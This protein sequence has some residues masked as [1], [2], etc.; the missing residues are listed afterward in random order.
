MHH[1]WRSARIGKDDAGRRTGRSAPMKPVAL[2]V[3]SARHA[4]NP[5]AINDRCYLT[6]PAA[7]PPSCG[8]LTVAG[9]GW[10]VLRRRLE[11]EPNAR[12]AKRFLDGGIET[13][14]HWQQRID[15]ADKHTQLEIE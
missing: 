1:G 3:S 8:F 11:R 15:I 7:R 2:T 4:R 12:F 13:M 10:F 5:R 6:M 9:C 14:A